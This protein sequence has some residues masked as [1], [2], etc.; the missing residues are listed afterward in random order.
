MNETLLLES[1]GLIPRLVDA[2]NRSEIEQAIHRHFQTPDERREDDAW[3]A[4]I[5]TED[6]VLI[7][8]SGTYTGHEG[9]REAVRNSAA[10]FE[11]SQH[12]VG[13]HLIDLDGDRAEV[14]SKIIATHLQR[15]DE[16]HNGYTGGAD[17]TFAALRTPKGWRLTRA[18]YIGVW[19]RGNPPTLPS[20]EQ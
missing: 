14:R 6:F 1:N 4:S 16:P 7:V 17:Y 9:M 19:V 12:L 2:V 20:G 5:Y 15:A 10:I 11:R 13:N 8:P 3:L 18:E